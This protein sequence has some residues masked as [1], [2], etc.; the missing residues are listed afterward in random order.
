MS[1]S[2]TPT[3]PSPEAVAAMLEAAGIRLPQAECREVAA[4]YALLMP[5]LAALRD[6][7]L[8]PEAEPAVTFR[9]ERQP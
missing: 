5:M 3:A 9:A 4:G 1:A 8:P 7:P 6:P 2:P